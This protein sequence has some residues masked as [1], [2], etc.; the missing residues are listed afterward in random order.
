[1]TRFLP[2]V[3]T[4]GSADSAHVSELVNVSIIDHMGEV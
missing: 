2:K 1:M 4:A 3:L